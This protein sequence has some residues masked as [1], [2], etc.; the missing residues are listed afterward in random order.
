[1]RMIKNPI[2]ITNIGDP[3]IL[4][5]KGM[6]YLY[7][8]SAEDGFLVWSSENLVHWS[9]PVQAYKAGRKSFGYRD[10]WA[11]EVV[12]NNGKFIM[13]YSARWK[14]NKSLRIGAA[15]SESPLGP[16]TDVFDGK[17]MFDL[18]YAA[19]DGHI[20]KDDDGRNYIYYSRDCSENI[21][22]AGYWESHIYGAELS[23]DLLHLKG[24]AERLI[25]PEQDWEC[26]TWDM[27]RWTEGPYMLKQGGRYY[28]MYSAN[29]Y[30]SREYC[31]GYASSC[32]PLGP[33]VKADNNPVLGF[34]EG[35]VSGPG[36]NSAVCTGDGQIWCVYHV[37][38]DYNQPGGDRQVFLDKMF[39]TDGKLRIE[40]PSL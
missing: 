1:M 12:W 9:Q 16:F 33:F 37:H 36:H 14:E 7:A 15:E 10:F 27:H 18:G 35:K 31:I 5:W 19:I 28:L 23:E 2:G 17:P 38:T 22:E 8:T 32:S 20:F 11:P 3:F 26:G 29:Y 25:I 39:I 24:N 6:Y 34:V 13:H 40:G 21:T 4:E 30:A